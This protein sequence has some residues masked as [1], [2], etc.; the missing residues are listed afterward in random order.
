MSLFLDIHI[1]IYTLFVLCLTPTSTQRPEVVSESLASS[2]CWFRV[3]LL[4]LSCFCLCPL[5]SWSCAASC[6]Q[7]CK[8]RAT[9]VCLHVRSHVCAYMC[10]HVYTVLSARTYFVG[11]G[12]KAKLSS[13][14]TT[15][16]IHYALTRSLHIVGRTRELFQRLDRV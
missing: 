5:C 12:Y 15:T 2:I 7:T 9:C 14:T 8:S 3:R 11:H 13:Q 10:V 16:D 4:S 1:Y 6:V